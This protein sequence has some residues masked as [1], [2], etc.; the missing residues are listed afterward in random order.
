[1]QDHRERTGGFG[2]LVDLLDR[3]RRDICRQRGSITTTVGTAV[4]RGVK[5]LLAR[6]LRPASGPQIGSPLTG[7]AC[8]LRGVQL[9]RALTAEFVPRVPDA[10]AAIRAP[11]IR[12]VVVSYLRLAVVDDRRD[13]TLVLPVPRARFLAD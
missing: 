10:R 4:G 1:V 5:L 8:R 6:R 13:A 2:V 7:R 11:I 3:H 12:L 9:W